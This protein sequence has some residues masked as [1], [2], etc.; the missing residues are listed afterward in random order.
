MTYA[1]M[2]SSWWL[3]LAVVAV[4]ACVADVLRRH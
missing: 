1:A 2:Q 4:L 3:V